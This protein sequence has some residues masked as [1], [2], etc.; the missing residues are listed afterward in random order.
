[1]KHKLVWYVCNDVTAVISC[2]KESSKYTR[3]YFRFRFQRYIISY[4]ISNFVEIRTE[5]TRICNRAT[6]VPR[7]REV[8]YEAKKCVISKD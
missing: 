5:I 2:D 7:L 6:N 4:R 1:M 8:L 3:I